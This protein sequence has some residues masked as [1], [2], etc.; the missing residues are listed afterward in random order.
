MHA[1]LAERVALGRLDRLRRY[2]ELLGD[3]FRF[4]P[5][6]IEFHHFPLAGCQS[7]VE[8]CPT[9]DTRILALA[10]DRAIDLLESEPAS[11]VYI[12]LLV[13]APEVAADEPMAHKVAVIVHVRAALVVNL[14]QRLERF[15]IFALYAGEQNTRQLLILGLVGAH[16]LVVADHYATI[17]IAKELDITKLAHL[18]LLFLVKLHREELIPRPAAVA[19]MTTDDPRQFPPL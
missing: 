5:L 15:G 1:S 19:R 13:E 9:D 12:L 2:V 7:R 6:T 16:A 8:L 10:L 18:L 3:L 17:G 11:P 4:Q 14:R